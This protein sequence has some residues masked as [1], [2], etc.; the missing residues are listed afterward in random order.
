MFFCN[1]FNRGLKHPGYITMSLRDG[2]S[3]A[4]ACSTSAALEDSATFAPVRPLLWGYLREKLGREDARTPFGTPN[5]D[6]CTLKR[7]MPGTA[8]CEATYMNRQV[9]LAGGG[10][11][12]LFVITHAHEFRAAGVDLSLVDPGMLWYS[13]MATGMLSGIYSPVQDRV[14]LHALCEKNG[15]TFHQDKVAA[16]N[17]Q[18][19][20]VHTEAGRTLPYN[21]LSMDIGSMVDTSRIRDPEG[22]A[23]TVKP[24]PALLEL[25][26]GLRKYAAD[27][28]SCSIAVIGGG[29]TGAEIAANIKAYCA[30]TGGD[31][32]VTLLH[33]GDRLIPGF[34]KAAATKL[35]GLLGERGISVQTRTRIEEL[36]RNGDRIAVRNTEGQEHVFDEVVLATGLVSSPTVAALGLGDNG[37]PVNNR[38]AAL[39]D[40]AIFGAG[41]C[42]SFVAKELPKV[43]VFGVKEAPILKNNLLTAAALAGDFQEYEP[44]KKFL[45]ILNMGD[46]TGLAIRGNWH[47]HGKLAFKVKNFIDTRFMKKYQV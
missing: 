34:P 3:V 1:T 30:R 15:V 7:E 29:P 38:L 33:G 4:D 5:T 28:R 20:K 21:V 39:A 13:G 26:A 44:Q 41:D 6:H 11:A 35:T 43:G 8:D 42:I 2:K 45:I 40:D 22:V 14:D 46:G 24:I 27:A 32:D 36:K 47:W 10:H 17:T 18:A 9:L 37:I 19:K 16:L 23:W 25:Q 12:H 31:S